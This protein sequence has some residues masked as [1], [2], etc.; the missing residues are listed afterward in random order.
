MTNALEAAHKDVDSRIELW[1]TSDYEGSLEEFLGWTWDEYK[2]FV[3]QN[4]LPEREVQKHL[5]D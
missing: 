4:V 3:E 1:H 2:R 5:E